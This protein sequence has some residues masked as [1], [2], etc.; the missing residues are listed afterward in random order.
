MISII[1][2]H[3]LIIFVSLTL[4]VFFYFLLNIYRMYGCRK[5]IPRALK[6]K[7][8][9][10]DL[11]NTKLSKLKDDLP[12]NKQMPL[13]TT[14]FNRVE[15]E[16]RVSYSLSSKWVFNNRSRIISNAKG[17]YLNTEKSSNSAFISGPIGNP[18]TSGSIWIKRPNKNGWRQ[19]IHFYYGTENIVGYIKEAEDGILYKRELTQSEFMNIN[20]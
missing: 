13:E 20:I 15:H 7:D 11:N 14:K 16:L 19:I 4:F 8:P 9:L 17:F 3:S 6:S 12:T 10:D 18:A 2:D 1:K 5:N